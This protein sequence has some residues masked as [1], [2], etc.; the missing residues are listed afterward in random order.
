MSKNL[1]NRL[2]DIFNPCGFE[3]M[4]FA[5]FKAEKEPNPLSVRPLTP[6]MPPFRSKEVDVYKNKDKNFIFVEALGENHYFIRHLI[7]SLCLAY[8]Q[9]AEGRGFKNNF[10]IFTDNQESF[11]CPRLFFI[12]PTKRKD[13]YQKVSEL[14]EQIMPAPKMHPHYPIYHPEQFPETKPPRTS[15]FKNFPEIINKIAEKFR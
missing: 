5:K 3:D 10:Y 7:Y 1:Y 9:P 11:D 15:R 8:P 2:Q 6:L 4:I 12:I 14:K 13:L